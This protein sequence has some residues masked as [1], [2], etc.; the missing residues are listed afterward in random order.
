[1]S[2]IYTVNGVRVRVPRK[3]A[4]L[5]VNLVNEAE[6]NVLIKCIK[7]DFNDSENNKRIIAQQDNLIKLLLT[8]EGQGA[9][10]TL[11]GLSS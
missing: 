7:N 1:M 11:K 4:K 5:I 6:H 10:P 3:M 8:G 2:R 9:K